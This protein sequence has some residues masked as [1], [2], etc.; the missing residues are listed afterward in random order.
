[1]ENAAKLRVLYMED[2]AGLAYLL[3]QALQKHNYDVTI[4]TNGEDGI[5]AT[6][7][8]QYDVLLIDHQ[9]PYMT[10]IEVI[11]HL[12]QFDNT[13]PIIVLTGEGSEE[14]AV[15]AMRYGAEDYV[16][17]DIDQRFLRLLPTLIQ[18]VINNRKLREAQNQAE[19]ALQVERERSQLLMTFI[20]NA[21]HEFR[22]PL[23][24]IATKIDRLKR[25]IK[26]EQAHQ[27]FD[28]IQRQSN[29]I[30]MLVDDLITMSQLDRTTSLETELIDIN[31]VLTYALDQFENI[32]P[33]LKIQIQLSQSPLRVQGHQE[34]LLLA[35]TQ[36]LH[37]A[38]SFSKDDGQLN[39]CTRLEQDRIIVTI[40]DKGIGISE[41]D[42]T[43]VFER[44]YRVNKAHT[45]RG[46]GLGLPMVQ[47]IM[48]LH[49]G[50]IDIQSNL[51][52]GTA[53]SLTFQSASV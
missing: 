33:T 18:R 51:G 24:I 38:V 43:H 32:N 10:G 29:N 8:D 30:V 34:Y 9:M 35:F 19:L 4:V 12:S 31:K 46:F 52:H 27:Q 21:S 23:T 5:Q 25:I 53:V 14:I 39:V 1:M 41:A 20:E 11:R 26:D 47:R 16:V 42:L 2:D 7:Q 15:E 44:F 17:K 28:A 48:Q 50:Q 36:L 45:T 6:S 13:P 22:T 40:E 37:N 49:N 3:R